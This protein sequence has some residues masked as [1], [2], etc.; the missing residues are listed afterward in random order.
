MTDVIVVGAG[1]SG[2]TVAMEV[3]QRGAQVLVLERRIAPVQSRA[4]SVLPRVLELLD[5][6]GLAQTF[7]DRARTIR[8][9][10]LIQVHIWAGMQPVRWQYLDSQ[11]GYRLII[12][13]NMTEEMLGA[14]AESLGVQI[15]RGGTVTA[16]RQDDDGVSVTTTFED[17][18]EREFTAA[19]LVG[20]DGGRSAVRTLSG[21]GF[22][23]HDA[24]FTGI[25]ADLI[26][27][28]PWPEVRRGNDNEHGWA[29]SFPFGTDSPVTR[30]NMVHA[31]RRRADRLEPV[32]ADEV[33]RCL[34]DIMETEV[35]F[36]ELRWASRYSDAMRLATTFRDRR[37]L[38]VGESTR[39]HY[40]ASGV[41]MNFCIQDAFNLGWKLAAVVHGYASDSL[42]DSYC[43]ER[44]PVTEALLESVA[45][46]CA[47][48]FDFSPEGIAF[49][50]M[51]QREVMPL[52]ETNRALALQ[53]NG[54]T[55]PYESLEGD[56]P[57]TGQRAPEL[58]LQM[59]NGI[60]R[61][62]ELLRDQE[63]VLIDLTG[64][65]SF[66]HLDFGSAPVAAISG[67]LSSTPA[68]LSGVTSLLVRPDSYIGWVATGE[69][70]PGC[71]AAAVRR[72]LDLVP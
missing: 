39:I 25:I 61:L 28:T 27:D 52:P 69:P 68:V 29:T 50:R 54:L 45:S 30:F 56:H 5:A 3:A 20:A 58:V 55:E 7:I 42:L 9:N 22:E 32:T 67:V 26:I 15:E 46:Q 4:G 47:V 65:A 63:I 10:P 17:G 34:G 6:R 31:E 35:E 13:Q 33:R 11:F 36:S 70:D 38:L 2:L 43:A 48:Q 41:G 53:L 49:K 16:L 64:N 72:I 24:T 62:G 66:D 23:G 44:R 8:D 37:V 51:F 18:S 12:P 21:I 1:P 59:R 19:Y 71:A 14:R 60:V 40:P 57:L